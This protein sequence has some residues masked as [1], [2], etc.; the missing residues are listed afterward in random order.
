MKKKTTNRS[1]Q[2]KNASP[3][4]LKRDTQE[5]LKLVLE[6]MAI[7][8]K[9]CEEQLIAER[10]KKYLLK[11]GVDPKYI[12]HDSAHRK[13]PSPGQVGNLIVKLPGTIKA[14]RRMLMAHMDTVP[15]CVGSKPVQ[16]GKMI[17][18]ADPNTGLGADDRAGVA[19]TLGTVLHLLKHNIPHPPLTLLW[20]IHEEGGL[21][22][23]R[24]V[25]V[26]MLG[27]PKLSFNFD[28]GAAEKLTIGATGGYRMKAEIQGIA[29]HAGIAPEQGVSALAIAGIAIADLQT[30]GWHGKVVKGKQTGTSNIGI[31]N[32][33]NAT[34]VVA[35]HALLQIE[36]RS[37]NSIF[38]K[39]IVKEIEKAFIKAAKKVKND[40]GKTGSVSFDGQLDYDSFVLKKNE[41]SVVAAQTVI[42]E[43]GMTPEITIA[44]GGLD[45][46]W[47][48]FHGIPT[49]TLGCGQLNQHMTREALNVT[50]YEKA[51]Q[52]ALKLATSQGE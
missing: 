15:V 28:G 7:P 34:N 44:N 10:I 40:Q 19:V 43:L 48:T 16:K 51:C 9:S 17:R 22:G 2:K 25:N 52:I 33:G 27:N 38:R 18:S 20:T 8:G 39:R 26:K 36:A 29:S 1:S 32:G 24:H 3:A 6:L 31:L 42:A 49:V 13:I 11:A 5:A 23:A 35:D 46:N 14:P 30:N 37:H 45:A 47:M 21:H 12:K 41:P 4:M 50:A